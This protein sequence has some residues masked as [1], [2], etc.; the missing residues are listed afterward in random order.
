MRPVLTVPASCSSVCRSS[1]RPARLTSTFLLWTRGWPYRHL[2]RLPSAF[3]PF[4]RP[5]H[6]S[7]IHGL[8][9]KATC[10]GALIPCPHYP[11]LLL[12]SRARNTDAPRPTL[13][14]ADL[15]LSSRGWTRGFG[16]DTLP[17][18]RGIGSQEPLFWGLD[19]FHSF[20]LPLPG[21]RLAALLNVGTSPF[22]S[23]P[24]H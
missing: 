22:C 15:L 11:V 13:A 18:S 12:L 8:L 24:N 3:T 20:P 9:A 5:Q 2:C 21:L 1:H 23:S 14:G 7:I 17:G 19:L 4:H 16:P 10:L 6:P